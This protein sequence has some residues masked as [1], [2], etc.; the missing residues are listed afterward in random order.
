MSYSLIFLLALSVSGHQDWSQIVKMCESCHVGHGVSGE[1]LLPSEDPDF[2]YR[3]HGGP[4]MF[5][6]MINRGLLASHSNPTDLSRLGNL[7]YKHPEDI[8]CIACHT[9]HGIHLPAYNPGSSPKPNT[10]EQESFEYELCQSCHSN[11]TVYQFPSSSHPVAS[12]QSSG[13]VPSLIEPMTEEYWINCSDCHNADDAGLPRGVHA[14]NYPA[15]TIANYQIQDGFEESEDAYL[16]C[17]ACHK[18][19]SILNNESFPYHSEHVVLEETTCFTCHDTHASRT[20]PWLL[21]IEDGTRNDRIFPDGS[22][23]K[24]YQQTGDRAGICYLTCH[25]VDHNGW[26]YGPDAGRTN[27]R[28]RIE[29]MNRFSSPEGMKPL[30]G[31]PNRTR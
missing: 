8:G 17:Y 26:V 30:E 7:P 19:E 20:L 5:S 31:Q 6:E 22:G 14:S 16:L 21:T 12:L 11:V 13:K 23:R 25:G 2:C 15:I 4:V 1:K 27:M 28:R 9:G 18:R 3:C 10:K 24:S 29:K